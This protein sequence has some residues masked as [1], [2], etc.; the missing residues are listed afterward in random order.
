MT[1]PDFI[2]IGMERAGTSWIYTQLAHHPDIWVPPLKEIH[3]FDSLD[4]QIMEPA[5]RYRNHLYARIRQKYAPFMKRELS[6]KRPELF[7]NSYVEYLMWDQHYFTGK[8]D[9]DWYR[10]LFAPKYTSG[11]VCG[12]ITPAYST[13]SEALIQDIAVNFPKTKFLLSVRDPVSRTRSGLLHFFQ[14]QQ[15]RDIAQV[16]EQEMLAWLESNVAQNRSSAPKIIEK[17]KRHVSE[18][19]LFITNFEDIS[20]SPQALIEGIYT[21]IGVDKHFIPPTL[22]AVV[23][24]T[25][26][27][28]PALPS[29][30]MHRIQEMHEAA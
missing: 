2:G 18:E 16:D 30:V 21:F 4:S 8:Q 1:T 25:V 7:K 28:P 3:Y 10:G 24:K 11:R 27:T 14:R 26:K 22:N 5:P 15:K 19:R 9:H 23:N 29:S 6:V 13:I 12:E 20:T 17:W